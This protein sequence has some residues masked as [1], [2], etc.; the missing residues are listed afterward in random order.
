VG[1]ALAVAYFV[2]TRFLKDRRVG[3]YPAAVLLFLL[4]PLL[5]FG[6]YSQLSE[7]LFTC[8][9]FAAL[10]TCFDVAMHPAPASAALSGLW[11]GLASVT[12]PVS[13]FLPFFV[14]PV[15][16]MASPKG[17]ALR[18]SL[19]FVG[20]SCALPAAWTARNFAVAGIPAVSTVGVFNLAH[21]RA[22]G[23]LAEVEA[24]SLE[25]ADAAI[26]VR[27]GR[28]IETAAEYTETRAVAAEILTAHP[29]LVAKQAVK[30]SL[31]QL[32]D[33]GF[34]YIAQITGAS[35]R[36]SGVLAAFAT[37]GPR[38]LLRYF[39]TMGVVPTV[40]FGY[41]LLFTGFV[42][43]TLL[44]G[45]WLTASRNPGM[46]SS[47]R[48]GNFRRWLLL[49]ALVSIYFIGIQAGPEAAARFRMALLPLWHSVVLATLSY[50]LEGSN[51]RS[52]SQP[53]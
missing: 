36:Q 28:E 41:C 11:L 15:L 31:F 51:L 1:L 52:G 12:R 26:S 43:V 3:L 27:T 50:L 20:V 17:R 19:I 8:L 7:L 2:N 48:I 34:I 37:Q 40:L 9:M 46:A 14:A 44:A 49:I 5:T 32:L 22:A 6:A 16:I 38:A 30:S 47:I 53:S 39:E 21:F 35:P 42:Y 25:Q 10:F 45:I 13:V 4:D 29:L 18:M 23:V 33:P 24:V